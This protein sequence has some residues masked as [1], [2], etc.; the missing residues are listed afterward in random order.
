MRFFET[1]VIFA[2]AEAAVVCIITNFFLVA[3]LSPHH[4]K[5]IK[6]LQQAR[7]E[8][9]SHLSTTPRWGNP[10]ECLSQRHNK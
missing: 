2:I 1:I 8:V 5:A 6:T 4:E 7:L 3:Y 9:A 10:A